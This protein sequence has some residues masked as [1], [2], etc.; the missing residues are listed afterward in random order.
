MPKQQV[1]TVARATAVAN[2]YSLQFRLLWAGPAL[3]QTNFKGKATMPVVNC[4]PTEITIPRG[5]S[6][7]QLETIF[8]NGAHQVE[9]AAEEANL[10]QARA[11][12]PPAPSDKRCQQILRELTLTAPTSRAPA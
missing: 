11:T 9:E 5:T 8:A 1:V 2:I 6:V 10:A 4:G 7:G 3:I 12:L